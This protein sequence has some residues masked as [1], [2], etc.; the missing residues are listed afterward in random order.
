MTKAG[1]LTRRRFGLISVEQVAERL[2]VSTAT[3]WRW[4]HDH[5]SFPR[6]VR[7]SPGCTRWNEGDIEHWLAELA[8]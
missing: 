7:L 6:P 4:V 3:I 8:E 2:G 5:D 1:K